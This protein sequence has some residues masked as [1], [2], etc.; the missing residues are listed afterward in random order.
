MS[1][2]VSFLD[3]RRYP[4]VSEAIAA[5]EG[6]SSTVPPELTE[7][8]QRITPR[9][10]ALLGDAETGANEAWLGIGHTPSGLQLSAYGANVLMTVPYWHRGEQAERVMALVYGLAAIVEEETGLSAYDPQTGDLLTASR[11]PEATAM[12]NDTAAWLERY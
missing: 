8:W 2:D 10:L 5:G 7:A 1:Y 9:A 4:S 3:L 11:A 6:Q 12:M